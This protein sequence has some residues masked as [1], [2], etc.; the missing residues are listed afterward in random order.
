VSRGVSPATAVRPAISRLASSRSAATAERS[1]TAALGTRAL[2]LALLSAASTSAA[3]LASRE[4]MESADAVKA[5]ELYNDKAY[6][7]RA[8]LEDLRTMH[9]AHAEDIGVLWRLTRAAYDVS[10]LKAT[11][12]AEKKELT[13][14]AREVIQKG[15]EL[16]QDVPEIHKWYGIILSSIGDYE[17]SKVSIAN[18]YVIKGHWDKAAELNPNDPTTFYLLGRCTCRAHLAMLIVFPMTRTD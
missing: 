7:R 15:L 9:A 14:Y 17:G 10:E 18:S 2:V 11:P 16:T 3:L 6:D 12:A 1:A 5:E 8:L 4:R 13:Y